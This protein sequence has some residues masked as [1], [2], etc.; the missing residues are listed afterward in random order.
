VGSSFILA[1]MLVTPCTTEAP[2]QLGLSDHDGRSSYRTKNFDVFYRDWIDLENF[3][4][5]ENVPNID[6]HYCDALKCALGSQTFHDNVS[7]T[8]HPLSINVRHYWSWFRL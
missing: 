4:L 5:L 3:L 6:A 1:R 8:H 2:S 7:H